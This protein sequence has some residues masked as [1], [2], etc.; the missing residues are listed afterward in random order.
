MEPDEPSRRKTSLLMACFEVISIQ[1]IKG[2]G[3]KLKCVFL[4]NRAEGSFIFLC[5]I[6][7][8]QA[9]TGETILMET[10]K[11]EN[12]F[13]FLQKWFS[14]SKSF[15]K[16]KKQWSTRP[17]YFPTKAHDV[18]SDIRAGSWPTPKII[19]DSADDID[20]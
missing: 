4:A 14:S 3:R 11:N 20:P 15:S 16:D 12:A 17:S 18:N 2:P 1:R 7:I 6:M 10:I 13:L 5:A 8:N 19:R 9:H